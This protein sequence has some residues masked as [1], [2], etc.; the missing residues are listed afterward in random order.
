MTKTFDSRTSASLLGRLGSNPNDGAAWGEFV[1][2]Y[3]RKVLEWCRHWKLQ[4][5]DAQDVTQNVLLLVARQMRTFR[6]DPQRSF[7]AWLKTITRRAWCD[8]LEAQKRPGQGSGESQVLQLLGSL[9]AGDSLAERLEQEYDRELFEAA[10]VRVRLRIEPHVWEAFRL[11]AF[12]GVSGAEAAARLGMKVGAVFVA[13]G[14]VQKML[15]QEVQ[16][17]EGSAEEPR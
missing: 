8:W 12:E 2:R 13:K 5:A 17:L 15:Q 10:T 11:L 14:R 3:G 16:A 7:R 1:R 9:E 6:Y 4:E